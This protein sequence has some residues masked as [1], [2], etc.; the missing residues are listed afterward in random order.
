MTAA[1]RYLSVLLAVTGLAL[2]LFLGLNLLL[3]ERALGGPEATRLASAWQQQS[4]GVTYSPPTTRTRPFKS[5]RLADRIA[6]INAIVLGSSTGMGIPA[7]LF[8]EPLKAYNFTLTANATANLV[9]EAEYLL[10]HH[11][12]RLRFMLVG[13][14]WSIGMI[15]HATP[16]PVMDLSP[17]AAMAESV[18]P[19][20]E[21]HRKIID[22]LSYP[23]VV[24]LLK[25]LRSVAL[26]DSPPDSFRHTFF[27]IASAPYR[28]A[29]GDTARD[30]DVINRGL[31]LG[32]RYDG[33]WTFGGEKKLSPARAEVLGR[34]AAAPSS[35]FSRYLCE[36]G[37][38]PNA[39]YL[40]RFGATAQRMAEL[41]GNLVFMLPPII[42]GMERAM[43]EEPSNRACLAR[44]KAVLDDWA[45][46]HNVTVIDAG[47]SERY[48]CETGEFLDEHHAYPECHRRVLD[49]YF[50]AQREGR[51]RPGLLQP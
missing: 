28:C 43:I 34:A 41:G 10:T 2:S 32:F 47:Q 26:A 19:P 20:V 18:H 31:C 22:A 24:N 11:A 46:Q 51:A 30:F 29:D 1:A 7:N 3:G 12:D 8:P 44:T 50:R 14:D 40:Q 4:K 42:P 48:G 21:L 9:G 36:T 39:A 5:L 15:Y 37:G 45:R 25:A 23:K 6:D 27:D 17:A 35:K 38:E 13:L 49:F 16:V 33:S